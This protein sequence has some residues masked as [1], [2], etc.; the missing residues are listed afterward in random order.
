MLLGEVM[1]TVSS[2]HGKHQLVV[3]CDFCR[4]DYSVIEMSRDKLLISL[5]KWDNTSSVS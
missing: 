3:C 4:M 1:N 2:T 5:F